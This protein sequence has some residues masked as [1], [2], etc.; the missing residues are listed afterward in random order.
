MNNYIIIL[1]RMN[2]NYTKNTDED[3]FYRYKVTPRDI[4]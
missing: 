1:I 3:E 2:N 4:L